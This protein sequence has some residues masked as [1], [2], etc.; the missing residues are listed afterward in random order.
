MKD[1]F[2]MYGI[3]V[4]SRHLLLIAD[5]MTFDGTFKPLSRKGMEDNCSPLQQMT[6]EASLTF[7]KNATLQGIIFL[8]LFNKLSV[9][10]SS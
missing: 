4:D 3:D 7:I 2:K 10:C 8:I 9:F 5:Y 1:V 6:F